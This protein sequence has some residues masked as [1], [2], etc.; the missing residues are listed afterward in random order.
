MTARE[1]F[2]EEKLYGRDEVHEQ[3]VRALVE[4]PGNVAEIA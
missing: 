3:I 1:G 4:N 2:A